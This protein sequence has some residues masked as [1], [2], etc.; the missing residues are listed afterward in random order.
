MPL[1][2]S[3]FWRAVSYCFMPRVIVGSFVP[4][5]LMMAAIVGV[6]YFYWESGVAQIT[7]WLQ[8]TELTQGALGWLDSVGWSGLRTV[9][10]PLILLFAFTPIVVVIT[11]LLV[12]TFMTPVML[13][14]V[15]SRRF[16]RL[17]KRHGASVFS[18]VLWSAVSTVAA[19]GLLVASIP[20]WF[21]PPLILFLPP[22]IWGWLTYRVYAFDAHAD[23]ASRFEREQIFK[24][25]RLNLLIMGVTTG[26]FG[27]AP[28]LLWASGA[29]FIAMAPVLVPLAI[30][31]YTLVFAFSS[32]WFS[33]Y[34][35]AVLDGMRQS[36]PA[37]VDPN[38]I[39]V[40]DVTDL[41]DK[42]PELTKE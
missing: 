10:A 4:L 34:C 39:D 31:I 26:Y 7:V 18:S 41:G 11:L 1:L 28:S 35:L 38:V 17:E 29:V 20:L 42:P 5:A 25:H 23:H 32:L 33:H 16:A 21:I 19:I 36:E 2:F 40:E 8:D 6:G 12:A 22:L 15:A 24:R 37:P 30:W 27:A 14:L 9:V 13:N 3:S